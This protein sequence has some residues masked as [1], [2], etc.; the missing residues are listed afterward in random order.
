[1]NSAAI[2]KTDV[3][4]DHDGARGRENPAK[5]VTVI[6]RL[7]IMIVREQLRDGKEKLLNK[8]GG[9]DTSRRGIQGIARSSF[10]CA[11]TSVRRYGR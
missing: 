5:R 10:S 9:I 7:G 6:G 11:L 3:D 8:K 1:M 2:G 4:E